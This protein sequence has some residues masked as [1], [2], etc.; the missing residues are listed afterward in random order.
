MRSSGA[1]DSAPAQGGAVAGGVR[2]GSVSSEY[3]RWNGISDIQAEPEESTFSLRAM[4]AVARIAAGGSVAVRII[5]RAGVGET[6]KL[7]AVPRE[8]PPGI[9]GYA[10]N[11]RDWTGLAVGGV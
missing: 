8:D 9:A 3:R 10:P 6:Q 11:R 1:A 4:I 2:C 7:Q 5:R